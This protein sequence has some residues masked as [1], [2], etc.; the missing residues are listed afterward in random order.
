MI[1]ASLRFTPGRRT[2]IPLPLKEK[3]MNIANKTILITGTNRGVGQALVTEA[4]ERGAKR[5]YAATRMGAPHPD[6]R[7]V[8]LTLDVTNAAQIRQAAKEV[9]NLDVLINNAGIVVYD[10]FSD[11]TAIER[12]LAVN[13]FGPFNLT[14]AFLRHLKR[15]K[16]AVVNTIS[17]A[18]VAAVPVMAGYSLSKAAS[19]NMTQALRALLANDG[20]TVQA[21]ILGPVDTEMN[22]GL[23][24]PK[25]STADAARGIFAG[26]ERGEQE[27]FPDP[28]SQSIAAGWR[29]GI[30]KV[31]EG[32][33]AAFVPATAAKVA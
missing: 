33:F 19:L 18:A 8:A 32:Q 24:I 16:G 1:K 20:V 11:V 25:A 10:D 15:S 28:T 2:F 31:L 6:R 21:V 7:V 5:V 30:A 4:L 26:I 29:N 27:I 23:N 13:L 22:R 12:Q 17:M 14:R 9:E 3:R